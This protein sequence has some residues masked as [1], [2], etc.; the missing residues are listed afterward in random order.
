MTPIGMDTI[1][2]V[3]EPDDCCDLIEATQS[4]LAFWD[5]PADDADWNEMPTPND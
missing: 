3:P 5:N 4:S 2:A 1:V